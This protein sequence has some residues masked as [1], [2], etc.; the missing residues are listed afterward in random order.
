MQKISR[1][2]WLDLSKEDYVDYHDREWGVPIYDDHILFEFIVL[3]LNQAGLNWY[4]ILK[5]RDSFKVAYANYD[6]EKIVRYNHLDIEN[7]MK[8]PGIIRHKKKIEAVINNAKCFLEVQQ[9]Y[10]SFNHFLW[11]FVDFHPIKIT[12]CDDDKE[13]MKSIT[14]Q[15]YI[16]LKELGFLFMGPIICEAYLKACGVFNA[17]DM[18]CF[19]YNEV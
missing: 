18:N 11:S 16:K 10:K 17:H 12:S 9:S 4:T 6:L 1:C 8:N 3:E 19:R 5:R 2:S 14:N 15:F 7:L 13:L